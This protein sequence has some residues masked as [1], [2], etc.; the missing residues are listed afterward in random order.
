M[1]CLGLVF[2]RLDHDAKRRPTI[3]DIARKAGVSVATVNRVIAGTV[4]VRGETGRRV[5]EAA[6]QIGYHASNLIHQKVSADLPR[7]RFG[8]MLHNEDQPY[9]RALA[10][11]L[12]ATGSMTRCANLRRDRSKPSQSCLI[13]RGVNAKVILVSIT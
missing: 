2:E 1:I 5:S 12:I 9:Y 8:F 13:L 7:V 3:K 11:R 10:E 6:Q 4:P